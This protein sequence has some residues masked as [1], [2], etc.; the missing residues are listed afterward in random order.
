MFAKINQGG[1]P[2]NLANITSI[3]IQCNTLK[4]MHKY[5]KNCS[6]KPKWDYHVFISY[7]S[8]NSD[9]ANKI[10]SALETE[11]YK[12]YLSE[13]KDEIRKAL[14][15]SFEFLLLYSKQAAD[16]DW[17]KTE[18]GAAWALGKWI[19]PIALN[20]EVNELP[21]WLRERHAYNFQD[22]ENRYLPELKARIERE[23][24]NDE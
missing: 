24:D 13:R 4:S 5:N 7:S 12:P 8:R 20:M 23:E 11:G 16:S 22:F 3:E 9:E 19:T 6:P 10:Y 17:V 1:I 2:E 14:C 18:Y 21:E 15:G